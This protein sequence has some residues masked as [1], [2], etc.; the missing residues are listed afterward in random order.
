ARDLAPLHKNAHFVVDVKSTCL[1][2]DDQILKANG[3]T[4]DYYKTGHSYIKRRVRELGALAGFEKSGHFFFNA[5][6]GRGYDDGL[7]T[8]IE[9]AMMLDRNP[10][11]TIAYLHAALPKTF[12][13]P[14]MSPPC[15]DE[16]KYQV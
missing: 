15:A 4:T 16:V 2:E 14:T 9:I 8:G 10:G 7:L 1:F 3:A 11:K 13:T 12:G 5:P 6:L